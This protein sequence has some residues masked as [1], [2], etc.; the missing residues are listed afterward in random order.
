MATDGTETDEVVFGIVDTESEGGEEEEG[1]AIGVCKE[2]AT[3]AVAVFPEGVESSA[4]AR[5]V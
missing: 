2:A 3:G 1:A 5:D 4:M